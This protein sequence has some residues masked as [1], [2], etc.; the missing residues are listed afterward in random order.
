M[1]R[2]G[3]SPVDAGGERG[4]GTATA[5]GSND[6]EVGNRGHWKPSEDE[7][8]RWLV[9]EY[10]P[11]NWNFVA[12]KLPGRSGKSCRLRWFNQLDPRIKRSPLTT[13]EEERLLAAHRVYGNRWALITRLFPGR[14]DNALKNHWH[15]I[16]ARMRRVQT[17]A[18]GKGREAGRLPAFKTSR[19]NL[20]VHQPR[21]RLS[22]GFLLRRR[23]QRG[24]TPPE[25]DGRL[26]RAGDLSLPWTA[27]Q[28]FLL[29]LSGLRCLQEW[30]CP[31][32]EEEN[33]TIR[34]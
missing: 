32:G 30:P 29:Q 1:E 27:A 13:E 21:A 11:Q 16:N 28:T 31:S 6:Q 12:E 7:T 18:V 5:A 34:R 2:T 25:L 14:T 26:R 17:R 10:G 4:G 8:L 15:V 24:K 20:S 3:G 22:R 19:P 33:R 23:P 9:G